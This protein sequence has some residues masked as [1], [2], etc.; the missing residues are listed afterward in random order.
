LNSAQS[1][2]LL[3]AR[4]AGLVS[5]LP[6]WP[7]STVVCA[8][9]NLLFLPTLDADTKQR[10]MGRVVA[11][12]VS[13]AGLDCRVRLASFGFLPALRRAPEVTIRACAWDYYRLARRLEDPDTLFFSRRLTIDGDT[14][15]GLLVKNA[16]DAIDWSRMTGRLGPVIDRL[17]RL[18][19]RRGA[20]HKPYP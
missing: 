2:P 18:A 20:R 13:D 12:Q 7:P 10:L 14:E 16:L 4:L 11:V 1:A 5:R 9:L 6:Q 8:A 3:P 15:L 17:R 19:E